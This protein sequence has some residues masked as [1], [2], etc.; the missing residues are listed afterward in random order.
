MSRLRE[1]WAD[2]EHKLSGELTRDIVIIAGAVIL[3]GIAELQGW[4]DID[5]AFV[6]GVLFAAVQHV[7]AYLRGRTTGG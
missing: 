5:R 4:G 3:G 6:S 2:Y 7:V 1:W